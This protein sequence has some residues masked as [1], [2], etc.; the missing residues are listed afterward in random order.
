L[1]KVDNGGDEMLQAEVSRKKTW[2][3]WK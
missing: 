1:S 2:K 3:S